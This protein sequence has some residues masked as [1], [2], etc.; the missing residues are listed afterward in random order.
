[1]AQAKDFIQKTAFV[2]RP[3]F[4]AK[5]PYDEAQAAAYF[6]KSQKVVCDTTENGNFDLKINIFY[7]PY[8]G[9]IDGIANVQRAGSKEIEKAIV[10]GKDDKFF[11]DFLSSGMG[12]TGMRVAIDKTTGQ[13]VFGT[14]SGEV[15]ST[16]TC[17]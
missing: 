10:M 15:K 4:D 13:G 17:K 3:S 5:K 7:T 2:A 11:V 6:A 8:S 12:L 1:M 16:F 14:R 9:G